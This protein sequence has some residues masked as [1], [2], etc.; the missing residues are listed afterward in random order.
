MIEL[1]LSKHIPARCKTVRFRW[2]KCRFMEMSHV[3]RE[4]RATTSKPMDT[5]WWCRHSFKDGEM[6]ALAQPERGANVVLC[7]SCATAAGAA[8]E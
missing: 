6:M 8:E 4:I 7:Q 3:Y 1:I 2:I 5:C